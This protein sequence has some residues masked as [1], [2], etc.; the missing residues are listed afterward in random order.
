MAQ[1]QEQEQFIKSL[2]C[3]KSKFPKFCRKKT[4]SFECKGKQFNLGKKTKKDTFELVKK[5]YEKQQPN[6]IWKDEWNEDKLPN[7]IKFIGDKSKHYIYGYIHSVNYDDFIN[8]Y[9]RLHPNDYKKFVQEQTKCQ[10][11]KGLSQYNCEETLKDEKKLE[12]LLLTDIN[13]NPYFEDFKNWLKTHPNYEAL[14]KETKYVIE[15]HYL[16]EKNQQESN[17][18]PVG[19]LKDRFYHMKNRKGVSEEISTDN[20][21]RKFISCMLVIQ[22]GRSHYGQG[23]KNSNKLILQF[24]SGDNNQWSCE[25]LIECG[26]IYSVGNIVLDTLYFQSSTQKPTECKYDIKKAIEKPQKKSEI[27][28]DQ[29]YYEEFNKLEFSAENLPDG[30]FK[31]GGGFEFRGQVMTINKKR[32]KEEAFEEIKKYY[33]EQRPTEWKEEYNINN[34]PDDITFSGKTYKQY[35]YG[36][37]NKK[38]Y[39]DFIKEYERLHTNRYT[40]QKKQLEINKLRTDEFDYYCGYIKD[41]NKWFQKLYVSQNACYM[42]KSIQHF[43]R[44]EL[45]HMLS[46][47]IKGSAQWTLEKAKY[48]NDPEKCNED[49]SSKREEQ[50]NTMIKELSDYIKT[51][52][53]NK[54]DKFPD[55]GKTGIVYIFDALISQCNDSSRKRNMSIINKQ[56]LFIILYKQFKNQKMRCAYSNV[57][58]SLNQMFHNFAMSVERKN[59]KEGYAKDN[60]LLV[61]KEF[62]TGNDHQWSKEK[63]TELRGF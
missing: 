13:K 29:V 53:Q 9:K 17:K 44:H 51:F 8:E 18:T 33:I 36:R 43:E 32:N 45:K 24:T 19:F 28:K 20:R 34:R 7:D 5:Y 61:C 38:H 60:I 12:L 3:E 59:E 49:N 4:K 55:N 30:C 35:I 54:P 62:N 16:N 25:R 56:A 2:I 22:N 26:G 50:I 47:T 23:F 14:P 27:K 48:F 39:T 58:M 42:T 57:K 52:D 21:F 11:Y 1:E 63:L 15:E 6:T 10:S 40:E 37:I 31:S 46:D 41:G